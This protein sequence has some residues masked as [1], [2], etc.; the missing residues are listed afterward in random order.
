MG[1][2]YLYYNNDTYIMGELFMS[3][4]EWGL[5]IT[6]IDGPIIGLLYLIWKRLKK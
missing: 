2:N 6:A 3:L 1:D 4:L 5:L